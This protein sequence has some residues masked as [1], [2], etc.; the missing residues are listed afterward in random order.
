MIECGRGNIDLPQDKDT[1]PFNVPGDFLIDG[2]VEYDEDINEYE[3]KLL[4]YVSFEKFKTFLDSLTVERETWSLDLQERK[5]SKDFYDKIIGKET[6][7][8]KGFYPCLV[9]LHKNK[10][11]SFI[12]TYTHILKGKKVARAEI[13]FVVK[14]E[15]QGNGLGT[16]MLIELEKVL[17]KTGY[18]TQM[19]GKHFKDNIG[20]HKAF[21][22]A[23]YEEAR[24]TDGS[25]IKNMVW[26]IKDI[27]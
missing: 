24:F 11:I 9:I 1:P 27:K 5:N 26:K 13:S 12:N 16:K 3:I 20:S 8:D 22:K 15:Y 4:R 18:Y 25:S 21:L 14:K 7:T 19:C 6:E 17:S 10:I 2:P 23:G